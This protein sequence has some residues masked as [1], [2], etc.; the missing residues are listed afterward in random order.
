[1]RSLLL[2]VLL[3]SATALVPNTP[4]RGK[5]PLTPRKGFFDNAFKNESFDKKPNAGSGLSTQKKTVAVKIGSRTVQAMPGQRMKD[6]VRA[7]RAPIKFNCEDG[8]C[9]T[10]ESKVDGRVT[11]VCVA[12]IP[13]R[14]CTITRK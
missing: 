3:S 2:A 6:V 5:Q 4:G 8:Q 11:R 10:C 9:G 13:A 14:G 7:A 12:K 1:M